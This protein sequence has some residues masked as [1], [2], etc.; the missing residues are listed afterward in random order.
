MKKILANFT[1]YDVAAKTVPKVPCPMSFFNL[2]ASNG[3][4]KL[5]ND[6]SQKI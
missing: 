6:K 1:L 2:I 4:I 3:I 5:F